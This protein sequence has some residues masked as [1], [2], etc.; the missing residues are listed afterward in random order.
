M[1]K[2]AEWKIRK[3]LKRGRLLK[4][5]VE[6]FLLGAR[7]MG[8]TERWWEVTQVGRET[9]AESGRRNRSLVTEET[10]REMLSYLFFRDFV[11]VLNLSSAEL[12]LR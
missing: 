12:N 7:L 11:M 9:G 8:F 6:N 4:I 5:T 3:D 1:K 2:R 10:R